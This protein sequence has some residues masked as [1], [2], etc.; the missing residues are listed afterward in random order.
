M[1]FYF[2]VLNTLYP[3]WGIDGGFQGRTDPEAFENTE[4]EVWIR[5]GHTSYSFIVGRLTDGIV[6]I[7]RPRFKYTRWNP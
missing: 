7:D 1:N 3:G 5:V 2:E 4:F 6:G